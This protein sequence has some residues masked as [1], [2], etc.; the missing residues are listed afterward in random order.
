MNEASRSEEVWTY[1]KGRS[2]AARGLNDLART[3]YEK[4]ANRITFYGKLSADALGRPYAFS[5]PPK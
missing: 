5:H 4:I 2:Y 3:E 1:W